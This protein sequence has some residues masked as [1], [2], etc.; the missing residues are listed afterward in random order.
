MDLK[1][2]YI[3]F[4]NYNLNSITT[5]FPIS[6]I[7]IYKLIPYKNDISF[8]KKKYFLNINKSEFGKKLVKQGLYFPLISYLDEQSYSYIVKCG[9]HKTV[10]LSTL[11]Q[12]LFIPSLIV[13]SDIINYNYNNKQ[14]KFLQVDN[15]LMVI[16][17]YHLKS[18]NILKRN[19]KNIIKFEN[20]MAYIMTN[21]LYEIYWIYNISADYF[22]ENLQNLEENFPS[23][24]KILF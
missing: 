22:S 10:A 11:N 3:D 21:N 23:N 8:K 1:L 14:I 12:K 5:F 4:L 19:R 17:L 7:D 2:A 6:N 16:P 18:A 13:P 15:T 24:F 20:G 9:L